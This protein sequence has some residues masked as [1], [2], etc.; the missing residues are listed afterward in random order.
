MQA[1]TP[2]VRGSD[3]GEGKGIKNAVVLKIAAKVRLLAGQTAEC[4]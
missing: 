3:D 1:Y 4:V 2:L